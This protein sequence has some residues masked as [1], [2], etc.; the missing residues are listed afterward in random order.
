MFSIVNLMLCA[1]I[2]LKIYIKIQNT[3]WRKSCNYGMPTK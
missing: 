2:I 3:N 1:F